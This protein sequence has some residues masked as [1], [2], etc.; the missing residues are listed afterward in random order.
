MHFLER[1]IEFYTVSYY[2]GALHL[3]NNAMVMYATGWLTDW[4]DERK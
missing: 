2:A 3:D 1:L 4:L